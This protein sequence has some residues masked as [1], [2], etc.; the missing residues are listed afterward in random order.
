MEGVLET[1][2]IGEVVGDPGAAKVEFW[3]KTRIDTIKAP[4]I[5]IKPSGIYRA[6]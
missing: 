6:W 2:I 3:E 5:D 4:I 1:V